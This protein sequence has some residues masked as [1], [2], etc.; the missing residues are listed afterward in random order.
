MN[1]QK[2]AGIGTLKLKA[3]V[4]DR[5]TEFFYSLCYDRNQNPYKFKKGYFS[6]N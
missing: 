3:E 5:I 4:S 6:W 1:F 2:K